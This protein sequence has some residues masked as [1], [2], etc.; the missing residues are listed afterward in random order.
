MHALCL[1]PNTVRLIKSFDSPAA[2]LAVS[3]YLPSSVS[4][5]L[6]M[7][8]LCLS[9]ENVRPVLLAR[10]VSV[11]LLNFWNCHFKLSGFIKGSALLSLNRSVTNCPQRTNVFRE[12]T[13]I[14]FGGTTVDNYIRTLPSI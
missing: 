4:L 14:T 6:L 7:T 10:V 13:A 11:V 3:V 2:L 8:R 12:V 1:L 5:T 9:V